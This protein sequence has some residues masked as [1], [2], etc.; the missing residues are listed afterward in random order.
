MKY[1]PNCGSPVEENSKFCSNCGKPLT[2]VANNTSTNQVQQSAPQAPAKKKKGSGAWVFLLII[3]AIFVYFL[4]FGIPKNKDNIYKN[5]TICYNNKEYEQAK[6]YFS[7]LNEDYKDTHLYLTL[8]DGHIY[9]YLTDDELNELKQNLDFNDTKSLLV[10]DASIAGK[11]L[12]GYWST[13]DGSKSLE[14]Y[15]QGNARHFDT[16]G[17]GNWDAGWIYIKDG[18]FGMYRLKAGIT[19]DDEEN[20]NVEEHLEDYDT[21]DLFRISILEK[22]KIAV[23]LLKDNKRFVLTRD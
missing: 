12:L 8:C 16:N 14:V 5:G 4:F 23:V 6:E 21:E 18:V 13:E 17:F 2:G 22:D 3:G 1:C 19:H 11:Y 10:S 9:E 20:I 15:E 7:Q